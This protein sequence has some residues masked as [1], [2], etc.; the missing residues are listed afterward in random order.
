MPSYGDSLDAQEIWALVH[1]LESLV[2]G[3]HQLSPLAALGEGP[4]GWMAIRMGGMMGPGMMRRRMMP[5]MPPMPMMRQ[6]ITK[7][8][9]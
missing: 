6:G 9:R 1:F 3:D 5:G 7:K 8:P 4:R 2:P